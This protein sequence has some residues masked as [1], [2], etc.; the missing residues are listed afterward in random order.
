MAIV[1][2]FDNQFTPDVNLLE[3]S[4]AP[5]I[6]ASAI[7][8][9][10]VVGQAIRGPVG[11]PT[12]LGSLA[13]F[14]RLFGGYH[15]AHGG[16]GYMYMYNLFRAGASI[17]DFVRI[18][19]GEEKAATATV[20]G[21][22]FQLTSA[23]SW[24]NSVTLKVSA[25]SIAGFV[26][27]LF[28]YGKESY[29]YKSVTFTDSSSD[30]YVATIMGAALQVDDFVQLLTT[31]SSNPAVGTYTFTGGSNGLVEG[32]A[33]L[34][35]AYVG[36]NDEL[37]GLSGL[38]AL[39]ADEEVEIIVCTRANQAMSEALKDHCTLVTVTP[40]MAVCAPALGTSVSSLKTFMGS[41]NTDRCIMTYPFQQV[42]NPNNNKKEYHS[43]TSF[44]AGLLST[45][46]Y[47]V[48]PS[49]QAI[50]GVIG[51]ERALTRSDVDQLSKSRVSPITL[52]AGFGFVVR[53][54]YNASNEPAKANI[55]RRRAVNFFAKTFETGLQQFVSRPHNQALRFEVVSVL[56]S[57]IQ[58]E[59]SMGK[60]GRVNG[61]KAFAVKCDSENNPDSSV[62]QAKMIV[63]VQI[64]LW[65][66][67]DFINVTLDASEAKVLTVA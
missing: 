17:V 28:S 50:N 52:L 64:S 18:T 46:S 42:L 11:V 33:L 2:N 26:D 4:P 63:D 15:A 19:D 7:G 67:A 10:G 31:G 60:I 12:R 13:D 41:F 66:P 49:R 37:K 61:G 51:T 45:L 39:E 59:V 36:V 5:S 48:S 38:V 43:P 44:Y 29:S 47:H 22:T 24:G 35:S 25:S 57:L 8:V 9:V 16:E 27:L 34:D 21:T 6:R 32:S 20:S 62:Q 55:T 30:S 40:R 56:N 1:S 65:S 14:T 23:G 58:N 54:G 53:N 3:A